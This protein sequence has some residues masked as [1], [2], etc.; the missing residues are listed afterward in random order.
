[1]KTK[2]YYENLIKQFTEDG[3]QYETDYD[4]GIIRADYFLSRKKSLLL[5]PYHEHFY[6]F[7]TSSNT[8][9][10]IKNISALHA[11]ACFHTDRFKCKRSR[12]FRFRIP[13]ILSVI[14]SE[15]GFDSSTI[16]F[17]CKEK[18]RYQMGNVN[19]IMLID[20]TSMKSYGLKKFGFVGC[21]PFWSINKT[22]KKIAET[23]NL[24]H[25]PT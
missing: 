17:V 25:N 5:Y 19:A 23:Y 6:F 15:N 1:M 14:I 9:A 2:N 13:I 3:F 4:L 12:W 16:D 20:L 24:A 11:L 7:K 21:L 22:V 8:P 18:Q 10:S